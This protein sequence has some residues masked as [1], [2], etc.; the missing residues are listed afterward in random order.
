MLCRSARLRSGELAAELDDRRVVHRDGDSV[1]WAPTPTL[2][3]GHVAFTV[4]AS[5]TSASAARR[6]LQAVTK[7]RT[8][9]DTAAQPDRRW[10]AQER[11]PTKT[12]LVLDDMRLRSGK[13]RGTFDCATTANRSPLS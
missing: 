12:D 9:D 7:A 5:T 2:A 4:Y 8:G 3:A 13:S 11:P 6:A 10:Q 1:S